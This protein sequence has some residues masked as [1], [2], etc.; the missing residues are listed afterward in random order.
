MAEGETHEEWLARMRSVG[1]VSRR[2]GNV[3]KDVRTDK[4]LMKQTT[5]ELN[6]L[7]TEHPDGERQD[8]LVR[9]K[10]LKYSV[11]KEEIA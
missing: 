8:V 2:S 9:P 1:T 3:V 11:H 4:G 5:D 6:T 10:H 7:I